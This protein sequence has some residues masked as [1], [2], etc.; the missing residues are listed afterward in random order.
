MDREEA[1]K[2]LKGGQ[3][4]PFFSAFPRFV[5]VPLMKVALHAE[6]RDVKKGDVALKDL[7]PT[8]CFDARIVLGTAATSSGSHR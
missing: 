3:D 4:V 8:L 6:A 1:I 5:A 2:L 7:I